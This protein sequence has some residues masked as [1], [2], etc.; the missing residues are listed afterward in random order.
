MSN[1]IIPSFIQE[2]LEA[3]VDVQLTQDSFIVGGFYKSDTVTITGSNE[4]GYFAHARYDDVCSIDDLQDIVALNYTW[5]QHSKDR[6]EGW[7]QPD[8]Q[9]VDLLVQYEYVQA[10]VIPQQTIYE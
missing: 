10:K 3:G 1:R 9:W 7:S 8:S 2:L 5:W 4:I 6:Y